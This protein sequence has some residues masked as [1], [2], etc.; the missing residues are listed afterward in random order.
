MNVLF[1]SHSANLSGAPLS[2]FHLMSR[3]GKEFA[4][5]FASPE[6]GPLTSRIE[7]Q[8]IRHFEM[9][10]KGF[11]GLKYIFSFKKLMQKERVD[12]VHLNTL[13]PFSK[14]AGIAA[15]L[16]GI[17]VVW[18]VRENP[19]IS[20]SRRLMRWAR[21]LA[22]KV[23]FV[24]NMTRHQ[25]FPQEGA[26]RVE[27]LYNGVDLEAFHPVAGNF[28]HEKFGIAPNTPVI[29]YVGM[30]TERKGVEY[31]VTAMQTIHRKHT[32]ARLVLIGDSA[33]RD[34]DY[35]RKIEDMIGSLGLGEVVHFTGPLDDV[36][37]ALQSLDLVVLPS[38]EERCSRTLIEA[39]ACARPCVATEVGGSPEIVVDGLNGL[40]V[41][42]KDPPAIATACLRLL[43]SPDLRVQMGTRGRRRAEELF[44]IRANVERAGHIYLEAASR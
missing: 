20:R 33:P 31:L 40:L 42:P 24:D 9:T 3:L 16:L 6:A 19:L 27:T 18:F 15:F 10:E 11:L 44:D 38:L 35:V 12:I 34:A 37:P 28:L 36:R 7:E 14:Y 5:L 2:C 41:P 21:F 29:G 32:D 23:V 13:T 1:V 43:S 17:P 25:S 22:K 30:L 8:G 26:P 4:P 39:L